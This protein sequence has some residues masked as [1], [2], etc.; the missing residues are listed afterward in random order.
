MSFNSSNNSDN[1]DNSDNQDDN[2]SIQNLNLDIS[3][4]SNIKSN[5]VNKEVID[6]DKYQDQNDEKVNDEDQ[7][8]NQNQDQDPDQDDE[9]LNDE[10]KINSYKNNSGN[11][12]SN[13]SDDISMNLILGQIIKE[14][15]KLN[16]NNNVNNGFYPV[17]FD[18]KIEKYDDGKLKSEKK[19]GIKNGKS[20]FS[21]NDL[22]QDKSDQDKSDQDKSDQDKSDQDKSDQDKLDQENKYNQSNEKKKKIPF[23]RKSREENQQTNS[24]INSHTNSNNKNKMSKVDYSSS[25]GDEKYLNEWIKANLDSNNKFNGNPNDYSTESIDNAS[26]NGKINILNWWSNAKKE[27]GIELKYTEK[28]INYASKYD[29]VESLDWWAKSGLELKYNSNAIDYASA[30]CKIKTLNWWSNAFVKHG[31]RFEYTSDSID[32][33]KLDEQKLLKLL[34]WWKS[35]ITSY[36]SIKFKYSREFIDYLESWGY[37]D[38][39]KYLQD[40]K[41]IP[42]GDK[43]NGVGKKNS[44]MLDFL[45]MLGMPISIGTPNKTKESVSSRYDM[46][47]LPEDIQKHIREKEEELNNNMLINGKAKEYIDNLVKIPFGKYQIEKIFTFIGDLINKLNLI[48]L[49]SSNDLITTYKITNESDLVEFFEKI[50]FFPDNTYTKYSKLFEKFIEIRKN[51][52]GYVND[53]LNDCVY[54]HDSTKKHIKCIISQWLSGGFKTGVVIG[55]QGPPGVGKTTM[56]KGALSKCLIDFID[57]NLDLD[58]PFINQID[59]SENNSSQLARPFCFMSLGGTTNGSTLSGHNITYHG[60]T[61][62]DIVKHLKEAKIMNPILYFDELDKISNTEHGHEISSVLTHIT[63]PVQNA[64]FTDRYFAEVKIDLSKCI[65]VFS[66][67]D[68][69]KIDRILLDRIQEI[70]LNPIKHKEKLVICKK[71]IIPEICSQ[72][73]YNLSDIDISDNKLDIIISEYTMEA[74]VRK[75]KEKLYEIFRMRHLDLIENYSDKRKLTDKKEISFEFINDTFSDYPKITYKKIKSSNM[76]GC[77]NGL[78][79]S[80]LGIGG[81]TPIQAKQIFSKENLSIGITGSVEKV[82][83]ES[84]K[85]AKTVGWNL[86]TREE[87]DN[88]IK[89]WDSRG[90][91][92]HFPD[93]STPKDGPSGGTAITC[94]IYSLLT[95]KPIK[96]N[97]AITGEIDLDGNVTEIGGL[98]AKL[99]GAKRAGVK[100]VLV[101]KENHRELEIVKKN[102]PGLLDKNF[103]VVKISHVQDALKYIF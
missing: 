32:N 64:H 33:A 55:I 6:H 76:V 93:G 66:Y 12:F 103:K 40:N 23:V 61:S 102:N 21:S 52:M 56:I 25:I 91:H 80:A 48:N 63:D 43:F 16:N 8:Q 14:A 27:Y 59:C 89:S 18:L 26:S 24:H 99:N 41:M 11:I 42:Q 71:F 101:P 65:I 72:L 97:V 95:N 86:L 10:D 85:V 7:D 92:I 20:F 73:G 75:L 31:W 78:Y 62:G 60:A 82:M 35:T 38:I 100:L 34:K 90:I 83:E 22:D 54:G 96:N 57:Y 1:S 49:A 98:D 5:L 70:R 47:S 46:D 81:I 19:F 79:A 13:N 74:G 51:Y 30:G 84:V 4:K 37:E 15:F 29:Q 36:P 88:V 28:A 58:E 9:K 53:V 68:T 44:N 87:Q 94:A 67:N 77:I 3:S 39:Y 45:G 2:N 17:G 50:K 69:K